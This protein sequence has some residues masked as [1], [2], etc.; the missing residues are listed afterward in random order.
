ML[1]Q[2]NMYCNECQWNNTSH[3]T[4]NQE[5][6]WDCSVKGNHKPASKVQ[7][8]TDQYEPGPVVGKGAKVK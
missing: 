2:L 4:L 3:K 7:N 5:D 8:T 6:S 1:T